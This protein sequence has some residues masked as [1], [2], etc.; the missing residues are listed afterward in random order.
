LRD[1]IQEFG[2]RVWLR[3]T[4]GGGGRGALPVR[5]ASE[6]DFAI[7]WIDRFGGWGAFTAAEHLSSD[8]VTWMSLWYEGTLV[9]G[10][11]RK[12]HSWA[13]S[14]RTLSGVTGVTG[15]ASTTSEPA[16]RDLAIAAI[17]AIDPAPHGIFSVDMTYDH[18]R[19]PRATEINIG[20]FFTTVYFFAALGLNLPVMYRDLA[21]GG[22]IPKGA[23]FVDPLPPGMFWIRGMDREPVLTTMANIDAIPRA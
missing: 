9:A 21:L 16:A 5:D 12:R 18:E 10:Q 19:N 23:P 15:V 17:H 6:V 1:A 4:E 3:A 20:R 7:A 2:G 13:F 11:G 22:G 8:S 14:D